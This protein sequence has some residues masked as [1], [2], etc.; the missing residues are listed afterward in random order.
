MKKTLLLATLALLTGVGSAQSLYFGIGT[1]RNF[2]LTTP[3]NAQYIS[4]STNVI[5]RDGLIL[6]APCAFHPSPVLVRPNMLCPLGTTGFIT[7]G[8]ID[9][10]GVAD[11]RSYWSVDSII[12]HSIIDSF[13]GTR[14]T[15]D[16]APLSKLQRPFN[17]F[18][19]GSVATFYNMLQPDLFIKRYDVARYF[20]L[21]EYD[22]IINPNAY[23]VHADEWVPGQYIFSVPLKGQPDKKIPLP[24]ALLQMTE[25]N[26][27]RKGVKGFELITNNWHQGAMDIDPRL[28]T[29]VTWKGNVASNTYFSDTSLFSMSDNLGNIVYPAPDTRYALDSPYL[30]S[31]T[32]VPYVFDK[33]DIGTC[34]LEFQRN[35]STNAVTQDVSARTWTWNARFI[36]SYKAHDLY[37]YRTSS[38]IAIPGIKV[39]GNP[40]KLRAPNADY[41]GDGLS[42]IMEFAFTQDD[43]DDFN[44]T[45]EWTSYHNDPAFQ[46]LPADLLALGF[47][48]PT[49]PP[50]AYLD[51]QNA[52]VPDTVMLTNKRAAVGGSITYGYEVCY[53]TTVSN[54]RW[55]KLKGP[56]PGNTVVLKDKKAASLS[57]NPAFTWTIIDTIDNPPAI[58][59]TSIQA[60]NPLPA[61]VR[62]RSTAAVTK[63]Y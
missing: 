2:L 46:P 20:Y 23:R 61:T 48:A 55:V 5:M 31:L 19:D 49:T 44:T 51:T 41:D 15:L 42:N 28:I 47:V 50:P 1:T 29:K 56:S 6:I 7:E 25:S 53:D 17:G 34:R 24:M 39:A 38:D 52:G 35:L 33:G 8:D 43:G 59:T 36:D 13:S 63:G 3:K 57:G 4:G 40:S 9:L 12:I 62:V 58:G 32:I 37:E 60:S 18:R 30:T 45:L 26:G 27:Y 10:D 14:T 16:S 21:R 54:P 22:G 11:D